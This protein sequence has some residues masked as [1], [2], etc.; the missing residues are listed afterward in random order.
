M[1]LDRDIDRRLL[2]LTGLKPQPARIVLSDHERRTLTKA[3]AICARAARLT[4]QAEFQ[5]GLYFETQV[6]LEVIIAE[7]NYE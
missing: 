5:E 7:T 2:A 6:S 3:R 4:H 1:Y